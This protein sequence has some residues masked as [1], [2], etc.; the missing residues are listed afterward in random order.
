MEKLQDQRTEGLFGYSIVI[1]DNDHSQ[2][3]KGMVLDFGKK[4]LIPIEYY[5]EPEQNIALARNRA[6]KNAKGD[7]VAFI[8]DDEF[9]E[10]NWLLNLYKTYSDFKADGVLGPVKPH[11]ETTP[12][13][14]IIKGK[15]CERKSYD[16]GHVL[17]NP[18]DTRTGN[19]LLSKKLL[20]DEKNPF[21]PI[22]GRTGGEDVDFFKRMIEKGH[23]LL[24]SNEAAVY[25][26][27][28]PERCKRTYM[29][30][31]ALLR[32]SVSA[33][34]PINSLKSLI[35]FF[36]YTS[37]LP[38]LLIFSHRIFMKYLIKDF[39]HIGKLLAICGI[40]LVKQRES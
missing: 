4:A 33:T 15:I 1:V 24:W 17:K 32:G 12:P 29:L 23:I 3:A 25:E 40:N 5:V 36:I 19:V 20:L 39:D 18:N 11:F 6:V 10:K 2:S 14:W 34:T 21:N 8:D 26:S 30:R 31:R 16:T 22:F 27:V 9:P 7:F 28:P 13:Q 38:L 35:A 37:A